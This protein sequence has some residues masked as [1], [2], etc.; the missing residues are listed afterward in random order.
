[1]LLEAEDLTVYYDTA[2]LLNEVSLEVG[3]GE[4]VGLVGPNGA[5][6]TTFFRAITGL[7]GREKEIKGG[8]EGGDI[9]IEGKV[10][11][12]GERVDDL[13]P[14]EIVERGL[15]HCPER[16]RPFPELTVEEN[17]KA[18]AYLNQ[19]K[20]DE[21]L[22]MVYDLFP[23]LEERKSQIAGK[24][25]GGEQQMLAIGRSLMSDPR[26]LCIDEPSLGLAPKVR[27]GVFDKI[28]KI[29]EEGVTIL[30]AEQDVNFA[31]GLSTRNYVISS[32]K[33]VREGTSE[34][35]LADE[36]IRETYLGL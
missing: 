16:S 4:L 7:V 2:L 27:G 15:V 23:I 22:E 36:E 32:A 35:L 34:E 28:E 14:H 19:D 31:F 29:N 18:G 26:L 24:M 9:T 10:K 8:I 12:A 33:I 17:L 3:E 30:L 21:N 5:G 20:M 6:K 13:K 25:S 1:M 11:F